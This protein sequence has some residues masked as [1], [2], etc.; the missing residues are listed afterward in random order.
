MKKL[1][2]AG[3][4]HAK[5]YFEALQAVNA[6]Y[7][8]GG[9]EEISVA[10]LQFDEG[11]AQMQHGW[12]WAA[13]HAEEYPLALDLCN[14]YPSSAATLLELRQDKYESKI[15]LETAVKA[16]QALADTRAKAIHL[17]NLANICNQ[18]GDHYQAIDYYHEALH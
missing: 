13:A 7:L 8:H 5:H 9:Q 15:W 18:L 2:E 11:W 6:L 10:L 12:Q 3:Y 14:R 16:A 1:F 17:S 4:R